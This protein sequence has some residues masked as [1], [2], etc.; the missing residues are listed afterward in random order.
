MISKAYLKMPGLVGR[1]TVAHVLM[2]ALSPTAGLS[3]LLN[4]VLGVS[5]HRS[6]EST[7]TSC[8]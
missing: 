1:Q 5:L 6:S 7:I 2:T 8:V 3:E 4:L